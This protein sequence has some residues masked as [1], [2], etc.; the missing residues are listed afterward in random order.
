LASRE[1]GKTAAAEAAGI[2][3][4]RLG[5]LVPRIDAE[6]HRRGLRSRAAT[7]RMLLDEALGKDGTDG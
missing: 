5:D 2:V 3:L 6:W 7:I 1:G 4:L